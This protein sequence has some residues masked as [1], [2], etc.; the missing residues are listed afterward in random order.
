MGVPTECSTPSPGG[1]LVA[2]TVDTA[3]GSFHISA[4]FL[5]PDDGGIGRVRKR[6]LYGSAERQYFV[7]G[8]D[9]GLPLNT[10]LEDLGR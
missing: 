2:S 5:G 3:G 8:D 4:S 7:P 10:Y 1:G 6:H 9:Y